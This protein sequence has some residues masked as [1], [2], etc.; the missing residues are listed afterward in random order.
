MKA[1]YFEE[2][3]GPEVLKYG[4]IPDPIPGPNEVLVK[5]ES[6]GIN[7]LDIWV[8]KGLP[9]LKIE[10]PHIPGADGAGVVEAL[11]EGVT[12]LEIGT[13]VVINP[14]LSCGHCEM[15]LLGKDNLCRHYK[16]L[17]EHANG[18]YAEKIVVPRQNILPFP[19]GISTE[20]AG[21]FA[22]VFLTAWQMIEKAS[23]KPG[24]WV[25]IMA[26]GSGVS[27]AL[28]QLAKLM[29]ANVVATSSQEWKRKKALELGADEV[30]DYT[31]EDFAKR[32][33]TITGGGPQVIFDHTGEAM[34]DTLI[35]TLA[36]GGKL[37]TCGA[38][39][40][41]RGETHI[42]R[43]FF[44]QLS[45]LGSTMGSKGTLFRIIRLIEQKKLKPV[46]H[47]VLPLEKAQDAHRLIESRQVF[48]KL[49]LRV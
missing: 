46:V 22:L 12:D 20:E 32:V 41:Y 2:H 36:W 24:D 8:R 5:L 25:L 29:G 39:T 17:G 7:H 11:G 28:I 9:G 37:V 15:C 35:A 23:I 31:A 45:I 16:I 1:V 18:T 40:G 14:G 26:A 34:W 21:S 43:V 42:R 10:F 4:D 33:K 47:D 44:K 30:V 3:G 19:A 6:V 13:R 38:T 49:V 48:G 27:T